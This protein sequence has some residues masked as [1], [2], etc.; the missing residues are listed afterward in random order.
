M[1]F[2]VNLLPSMTI[3]NI[4]GSWDCNSQKVESV[5]EVRLRYM[6]K[7]QE[8]IMG[9][10]LLGFEEGTSMYYVQSGQPFAK[11][12]NGAVYKAHR[13]R[14]TEG[15][16][17]YTPL[18]AKRMPVKL[19]SFKECVIQRMI[20]DEIPLNVPRIYRV[21][22]SSKY[23]WV[24]MSDL[25]E[26]IDV[27]DKSESLHCWLTSTALLL[28]TTQRSACL[29]TIISKIVDLMSI[30]H[31]KYTFK[32]GDLHAGNIYIHSAGPLICRV[33]LI[34]FGYSMIRDDSGRHNTSPYWYSYLDG[35]DMAIFL[36][37]MWTCG[38]FS[39]LASSAMNQWVSAK[40][41]LKGTDLKKF[42]TNTD[43]Y[44]YLETATADEMA[45]LNI[46]TVESELKMIV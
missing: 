4:L 13:I 43:V 32:H 3:K 38:T 8:Q 15:S 35:V 36:W 42:K 44:R 30:L 24:F 39:Q 6:P 12:T 10:N 18:I 16:T 21:F 40:L 31:K 27:A 28:S 37:S 9:K 41:V 7:V 23:L 29:N 25:R 45:G 14:K 19:A 5:R 17:Y 34:D 20:Y 26:P 22:R 33:Y 46:T 2:S 1:L 11:G